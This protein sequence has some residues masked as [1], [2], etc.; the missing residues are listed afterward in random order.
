M[1]KSRKF[2][3]DEK[4][5]SIITPGII[6]WFR[7]VDDILCIW[8]TDV[9]TDEFVAK[10]N[11]QVTSRK[12][13]METEIGK[14]LPFLDILIHREDCSLKFSFYRKSTNNLSYSLFLRTDTMW[15]NLFFPLCISRALRVVSPEF[16]DEEFKNIDSIGLKLCY[17]L[18]FLEV[19]RSKAR[20]TY[21]NN[22]CS[23][24]IPPKNV[25][26][27]PYFSGF[28]NIVKALKLF[29]IHVL[30]N[31]ENTVRKLLARNSPRSDNCIIYKIPCKDYNR[32]YVGQTS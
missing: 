10:L 14:C 29:D 1:F 16:F 30:F 8:P 27:L 4:F 23:E 19:C 24:K 17:P 32:F 25:L 9:N 12:L 22:I 3:H 20:R 5:V 7:Y 15:K 21:Y 18:S 13:T 28:E 31:Y 11:D 6:P 2:T 26:C